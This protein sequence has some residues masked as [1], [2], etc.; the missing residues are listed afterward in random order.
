[1]AFT[2]DDTVPEPDWLR[3]GLAAFRPATAAVTG[4]IVMPIPDPPTDYERNESG[5]TRA[6]FVTANC[7]VAR[8]ALE[9]VG[10]FD[11]RFRMAWR[12]DSDLQ[13]A[14]LSRG[15]SIV[16]APRAVVVHPVRPAPFGIGVSQHR[17]IVF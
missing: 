5:L 2:D 17:K 14:L 13:F 6:E 16:Q 7:F 8:W 3:E 15:M 12:E 9:E 10:G 4:R 1:I 11:E